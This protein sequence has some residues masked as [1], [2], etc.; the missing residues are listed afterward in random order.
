[1]SAAAGW[2]PAEDG[3]QRYW[4][5]TRWTEYVAP[6]GA[7][8]SP[9]SVPSYAG[10]SPA[11]QHGLVVATSSDDRTMA[12]LAHLLAL[13][14]GFL[15]PLIIWLIK[16]DESPFVDHHGKEALNFQITMLI[17]WIV[18]FV[19]ILILIGFVLIFVLFIAQ[20][21]FPILAAVAANKGETYR[22]PATLRIIS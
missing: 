10:S 20:L 22:Y 6:V 18:A 7:T 15:G 14:S 19:S 12:M 21:L 8:G 13:V 3:S 2:Y 11:G 16:K 17:A 5:G 9:G 4:D 1:M